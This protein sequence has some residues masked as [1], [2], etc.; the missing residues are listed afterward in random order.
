MADKDGFARKQLEKHGW[1]EGKHLSFSRYLTVL[2][3]IQRCQISLIGPKRRMIW[4]GACL[5][6]Y[7][8]G[9]VGLSRVQG[10]MYS[11]LLQALDLNFLTNCYSDTVLHQ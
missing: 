3:K 2:A 5:A 10:Y 7:T 6:S 9:T 11:N 8:R 1:C 4:T